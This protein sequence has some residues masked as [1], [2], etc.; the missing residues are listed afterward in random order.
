MHCLGIWG[1][2][3]LSTVSERLQFATASSSPIGGRFGVQGL[4]GGCDFSGMPWCIGAHEHFPSEGPVIGSVTYVA[5][6][7][8]SAKENYDLPN[9]QY[10]QKYTAVQFLL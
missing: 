7:F 3:H 5:A 1:F 4:F 9:C 2:G 6:Q 10:K 8:G